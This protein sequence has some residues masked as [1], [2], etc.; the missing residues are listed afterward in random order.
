ML[1][2]PILT[3]DVSNVFGEAVDRPHAP[4]HAPPVRKVRIHQRHQLVAKTVSASPK[5]SSL[6]GQ[7]G[8][9]GPVAA[10]ADYLLRD[11]MK[12]V[13][14]SQ[15][16]PKATAALFYVDLDSPMDG[17]TGHTIRVCQKEGIHVFFQSE[18]KQW[19]EA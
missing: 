16:F 13:G 14:F 2:F 8:K 12:V 11:T 18:W 4:A 9:K 19:I 5:T 17:G 10:K 3:G 7:L 15:E 6:M 1:L